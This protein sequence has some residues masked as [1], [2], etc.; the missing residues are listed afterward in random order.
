MQNKILKCVVT[1]FLTALF[2]FF[3][4]SIFADTYTWSLANETGA[5]I[6]G[7]FEIP[8]NWT[9]SDGT[10][11]TEAPGADDDVIIP[12]GTAAYTVTVTTDLDVA[13]LTVGSEEGATA[14]VCFKNG[15]GFNKVSGDVKVELKGVLSGA[16]NPTTVT[17]DNVKYKLNLK[18]GG[19]ME[20][21]GGITADLCG[22]HISSSKGPQ[23]GHGGYGGWFNGNQ[24][25]SIYGSI[26]EPTTLGARGG[27]QSNKQGAIGGGAIYLDI[28]GN[29]EISGTVSADGDSSYIQAAAAGGSILIK[30]ATLSGGGNIYARPSSIGNEQGG[31]GRIAIYQRVATNWESFTGE[32]FSSNYKISGYEPYGGHG[33]I[34]LEHAAD[35]PAE[36]DL[37]IDGITNYRKRQPA[38][39]STTVTDWDKPFGRVFLKNGAYLR[40]ENG[41]TLKVRKLISV[42]STAMISTET[43]TAAIEL[44]PPKGGTVEISGTVSAQNFICHQPDCTIAFKNGAKLNI[45]ATGL[46]S[47]FGTEEEPIKLVPSTDDVKYSISLGNDLSADSL[48][49]YVAI[50]NCNASANAIT[51]YDSID[52]GGNSNA[53]FISV[54]KPGDR[55]VW[56]GTKDTV[57]ANGAN[58][59]PSRIPIETDIIEIPA[60]CANYPKFGEDVNVDTIKIASGASLTVNGGATLKV[61]KDFE[62][63]GTLTLNNGSV[64]KIAGD[65][66]QTVELNNSDYAAISIEKSGGSV[67]FPSG[68]SSTVFDVYATG[69]TSLEFAP[70]EEVQV[71]KLNID[72]VIVENGEFK[73]NITLTSSEEGTKWKLIAGILPIIRGAF[74]SDCDAS[75]GSEIKVGGLCED[76][77]GNINIDFSSGAAY[78]WTGAAGTEDFDTAENWVPQEVPASG[79]IQINPRSGNDTVLLPQGESS[80][81]LHSV[82]VEGIGSATAKLTARAHLNIT[83]SFVI[84]ANG[85][86]A[87]DYRDFDKVNINTIQG[88]F[89]IKDG[90]TLTHTPLP[91]TAT[92]ISDGVYAVCVKVLGDMKVSQKG[93]VDVGSCGYPLGKGPGY[94]GGGAAHGASGS[95]DKACYGSIFNPS[96]HGSSGADNNY[97]TVGGGVV[98]LY[99]AGDLYLDGPICASVTEENK[100]NTAAFFDG[101][102]AGGSVLVKC[103][104]LKGAGEISAYGNPRGNSI[105]GG[106]RIAL[107]QY[108]ATDWSQYTGKIINGN[109]TATHGACGPIYLECAADKPYG[110]ILKIVATSTSTKNWSNVARTRFP[111]S[112]DA[113]ISYK[114]LTIVVEGGYLSFD[115]SGAPAAGKQIYIKDLILN[116]VYARVLCKG[117]VVT[118]LSREHKDGKGWYSTY[119]THVDGGDGGR[120]RWVDGFFIRIR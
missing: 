48:I 20:V 106:G 15:L 81:N 14:T 39:L 65:A 97:G 94:T 54:P 100:K 85:T 5:L 61:H 86:V 13:S 75:G 25:G 35:T 2:G 67:K 118:V 101:G 90:G 66:E 52:L 8:G 28:S 113:G 16:K 31:G 32:T 40:I 58:W 107:Y 116:G 105:A 70:G 36:G 37:I 103:A 4:T 111:M 7:D 120:V 114:D 27:Y 87:L 109:N 33:T 78:Y 80:L 62:N 88:D 38:V 117:R 1:Y 73:K 11:A 9:L 115:G 26:R 44:V 30:C 57:W 53:F 91:S 24:S 76:A 17:A 102:G 79:F 112:D 63:F 34:Y 29:L 21:L 23:K 41:A 110:G 99:I 49:Q 12:S 92:K 19:N 119:A 51:A 50:S 93:K 104:T 18:V 108:V 72:G 22:Y 47:I 69:T 64:L 95:T 42:D 98:N 10:V 74:I 89:L 83:D 3:C 77:T 45:P 6:D 60:G 56:Q 59:N 46:V 55:I 96:T 71:E 43:G 68:F 82:F 84:G